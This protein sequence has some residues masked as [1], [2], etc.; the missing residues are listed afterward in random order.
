MYERKPSQLT[1]PMPLVSMAKKR[2][3]AP[4]RASGPS[5]AKASQKARRSSPRGRSSRMVSDSSRETR[6]SAAPGTPVLWTPAAPASMAAAWSCS[7]SNTVPPASR[8]ETRTLRLW[9]APAPPAHA[10]AEPAGHDPGWPPPSDRSWPLW[11][12]RAWREP[13][14]GG[15]PLPAWRHRRWPVSTAHRAYPAAAP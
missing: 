1:A 2:R 8:A 7:A 9:A 12:G 10:S 4:W 13:S 11:L 3:T 15:A 14:R 5:A 6:S